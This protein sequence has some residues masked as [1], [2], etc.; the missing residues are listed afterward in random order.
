MRKYAAAIR[1]DGSRAHVYGEVPTGYREVVSAS[2][3]KAG[4]KYCVFIFGEGV[5]TTGEYFLG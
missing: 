3:L 4:E 5:E 1:L 2:P